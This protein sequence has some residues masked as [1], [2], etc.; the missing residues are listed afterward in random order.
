MRFS[1]LRVGQIFGTQ[2]RIGDRMNEWLL[3]ATIA[4][5]AIMLAAVPW[6]YVVGNNVSRLRAQMEFVLPELR[7]SKA[8]RAEMSKL[9]TRVTLLEQA[10]E[11]SGLTG[12][13]S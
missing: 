2:H 1:T 6:A 7:E 4:Q 8:L 9:A 13:S 11:S 3:T 12:G 10:C 5:T